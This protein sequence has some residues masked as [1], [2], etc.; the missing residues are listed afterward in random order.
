MVGRV[1]GKSIG[2]GRYVGIGF[3]DV[4]C[5]YLMDRESNQSYLEDLLVNFSYLNQNLDFET[6]RKHDEL[7]YSLISRRLH[8][9]CE[10]RDPRPRE[11]P[12]RPLTLPIKK[13]L[14]EHNHRQDW[15]PSFNKS[16]CHGA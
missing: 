9:A 16:R 11:F 10:L 8:R 3:S 14:L 15:V 13:H 7:I 12:E 5:R 4:L 6:Q 2:Q 1:V